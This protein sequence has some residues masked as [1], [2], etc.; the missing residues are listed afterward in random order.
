MWK[1]KRKAYPKF[2]EKTKNVH[3]SEAGTKEDHNVLHFGGRESD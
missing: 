1:I 2:R 3:D